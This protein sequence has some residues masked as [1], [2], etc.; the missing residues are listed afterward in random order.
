[1][2]LYAVGIHLIITYFIIFIGIAYAEVEIE[3][4]ARAKVTANFLVQN[5]THDVKV[6]VSLVSPID[7]RILGTQVSIILIL[8]LEL[9]EMIIE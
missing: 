4:Q 2:L 3:I 6:T 9:N 7:P 5:M 8:S 1:M